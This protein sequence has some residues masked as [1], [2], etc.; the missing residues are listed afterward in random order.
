MSMSHRSRRVA[1]GAA[2]LAAASLLAG[3]T[4]AAPSPAK[5]AKPELTEALPVP[6]SEVDRLD[7]AL[8]AEPSS[9]DPIY[10]NDFPPMEVLA[11]VCESLMR[12][13]PDF[14]IEPALAESVEQP[15]PLTLVYTLRPGVTFHSGAPLT[16]DDVVYSLDRARSDELGSFHTA[17]YA[18]VADIAATA[19]D[20]VTITLTAPDQTLP[21]ALATGAGRIVS[22]A[23][24][25]A[26]GQAFG[27]PGSELDCTGPYSLASW[28]AGEG[29]S[30]ERFDG[31]WD[32]TLPAL[33]NEVEFSFVRDPAARVNA[34]LSGEVDGTWG[35]PASGY[36]KLQSSGAGTL[37]FG[38]T[39]GSYVAM[40]TDLTGPLSDPRIREAL[41]L[42]IDQEGIIQA[43]VGGAADPLA[44]PASPGTWGFARED[45][46]AAYGE[47]ADARGGAEEAKQ[48][49]TEAGAPTEPITIAVTS[50]QAEMPI[51]GAEVQRAAQAIGLEAELTSLPAD[52]YNALYSDASAREGIDLIF[53]LWQTDF[54]DPTQIYQY[55]ESDNFFNLSGWSNADFDADLDTSRAVADP[56]A[57]AAALI[58]AQRIAVE[59]PT[60]LPIYTPYNAVFLGEGLTG[61]PT[62]AV[63]LNYPWAA[64]IGGD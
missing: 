36:A 42:S 13:S 33:V 10:P 38:R 51:I 30:L 37:A 39:S 2:V 8:Y 24:T 22:R 48:L 49:V 58:D 27:G 9:L 16:A 7:W 62:S 40:V 3:C 52:G 41:A 61:V 35:V 59:D 31:Y 64:T 29:I 46:E 6:T 44:T 47:I 15:D 43:A 26:Q 23:S 5:G 63:Q 32:D 28:R 56:Q 55:L 19:P 53:S 21:Q 34:L 50:S 57:R 4:A 60:W 1:A 54:P 17:V 14:E 25:E 18:N 20:Q 45:F 11:N 12:I